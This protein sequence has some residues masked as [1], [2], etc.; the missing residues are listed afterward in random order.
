MV[1]LSF[2]SCSSRRRRH[3]SRVLAGPRTGIFFAFI[4]PEEEKRMEGG[5]KRW[6]CKE[7]CTYNDG[8][9]CPKACKTEPPPRP[10]P[11]PSGRHRQR[12][13]RTAPFRRHAAED[14]HDTLHAFKRRLPPSYNL[15]LAKN[16][17]GSERS[18][19]LVAWRPYRTKSWPLRTVVGSAEPKAPVSRIRP[20][21]LVQPAVLLSLTRR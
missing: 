11:I 15:T 9:E 5:W 10:I 21:R 14:R 18:E 17:I 6:G 1:F 2:S 3:V 7:D 8:L 20:R 4:I 19:G 13:S 16:G 12:G